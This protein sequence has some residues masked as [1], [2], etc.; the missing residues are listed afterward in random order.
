MIIG[1]WLSCN[2]KLLI[3]DEPTRGIDVGARREVYEL[4]NQLVESDVGVIVVSSDLP[5]VLGIS[6]RIIVM[7]DMHIT[8]TV[9]REE[10]TQEVLLE[11]AVR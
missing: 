3:F 4:I 9:S 1:R 8:G 5:E 2:A 10:A 6:D 11:M 7:H